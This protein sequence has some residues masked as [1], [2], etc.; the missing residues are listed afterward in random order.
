MIIH[1][2]LN[3]KRNFFFAVGLALSLFACD[4]SHD[5]MYDPTWMREQYNNQWEMQFGE[6][7]PNHTWNMAKQVKV[8]VDISDWPSEEYIAKIYS[9]NP[10]TPN[11][12]LLAEKK[13]NVVDE[14]L[15][16]VIEGQNNVFVTVAGEQGLIV[17]GYF[18]ITDNFINVKSREIT[19]RTACETVAGEVYLREGSYW[20]PVLSKSVSYSHKFSHLSNV[21]STE[22]DTWKLSD[23]KDIVSNNGVFSEYGVGTN[24]KTESN[25]ERWDDVLGKDVVYT[26]TKEGPVSLSLNFGATQKDD[27]FGYF[28]YA[29][30]EDPNEAIRYVLLSSTNP[31]NHIKYNGEYLSD[32]MKL[33]NINF[34]Y[35]NDLDDLIT[36][37][38]YSL[39]YFGE[40][41]NASFNFPANLHIVFFLAKK[42][43]NGQ[44]DWYNLVNSTK[45]GV[46]HNPYYSPTL[47]VTYSYGGTTFM[48]VEDGG[49]DDMNDLLF[50][51]AGNF[52]KPTDIAPAKP[53]PEPQS[54]T[55]ACEDLGSIGDF[56]FNDVVFKVSHVSGSGEITVTPLA[57]GGTMTVNL[58]HDSELLGEIHNLLGVDDVTKMINTGLEGEKGFTSNVSESKTLT[59]SDSF[60]MTDNMGGFRLEI[61]NGD[62][63]FAA[64]I[65]GP[66]NGDSPQMICVPGDWRWPREW[67]KISDAYPDFVNWSS[68]NNAEWYKNSNSE[69][70][71]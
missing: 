26:T 6:I 46:K 17:N 56:D 36:G 21:Y 25:L 70:I 55:V 66:V 16:D 5:D 1:N 30:G 23:F 19:S 69:Y 28:Y 62:G 20:D 14:L 57:A 42:D 37:T 33:G 60:T 35:S 11:C 15:F 39:V 27:L 31:C 18:Q 22:G 45:N 12:I 68:T 47:A 8:N 48:G 3:M 4:N 67:Q 7:D 51:V 34:D 50:F 44:V 24:G 71:Y 43:F 38:K 53:V 40:D 13:C 10:I 49:D 52:N 63:R 29:D 59:V 54:W 2:I 32:N 58:Y 9:S 61:L 64:E 41:G 65:Q